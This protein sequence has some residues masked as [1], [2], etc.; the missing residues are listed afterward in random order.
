MA[1]ADVF[2]ED[3]FE[4]GAGG[5][6]GEGGEGLGDLVPLD[7]GL[8]DEDVAEVRGCCWGW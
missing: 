1:V 8:A 2:D 7:G 6:G 4:V 5:G 3:G